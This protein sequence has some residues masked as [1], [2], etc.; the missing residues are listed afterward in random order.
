MLPTS[1]FAVTK[2]LVTGQT[3]TAE[4]KNILVSL[5]QRIATPYV[6]SPSTDRLNQNKSVALLNEKPFA[7]KTDISKVNVVTSWLK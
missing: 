1:V 7:N 5:S 2:C 6:Y 4:R 3:V